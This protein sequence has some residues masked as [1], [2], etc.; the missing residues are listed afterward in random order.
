VEKRALEERVL[1]ENFEVGLKR[2]AGRAARMRCVA[3]DMVCCV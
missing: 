1:G 3:E 2:R